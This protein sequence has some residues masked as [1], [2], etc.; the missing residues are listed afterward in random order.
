LIT[1]FE[2][3]RIFTFSKIPKLHG[4]VV[5]A[6][7]QQVLVLTLLVR[8]VEAV[9]DVCMTFIG[10]YTREVI[11]VPCDQSF[12][13]AASVNPW[14]LFVSVLVIQLGVPLQVKYC[15]L[16]PFAH[17][18]VS[19]SRVEYIPDINQAVP[20]CTSQVVTALRK[21]R[22]KY[23]PLVTGKFDGGRHKLG[24]QAHLRKL[25]FDALN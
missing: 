25:S 4:P 15:I 22:A 19:A 2:R 6:A 12:V 10:A 20:T 14:W 9:D 3:P 11:R 7:Y 8:A 18:K 24:A 16:V 21:L 23:I 17:P 13:C 5:A 1:K